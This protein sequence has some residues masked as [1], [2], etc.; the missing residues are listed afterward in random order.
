MNYVNN[1]TLI[2]SELLKRVTTLFL[3]MNQLKI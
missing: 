3:K 1:V 2:V